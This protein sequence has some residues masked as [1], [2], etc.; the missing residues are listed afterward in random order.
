MNFLNFKATTV[1]WGKLFLKWCLKITV[2]PEVF[3]QTILKGTWNS[4]VQP[5]L[6]QLIFL[7]LPG[8]WQIYVSFHSA[9]LFTLQ[10]PDTVQEFVLLGRIIFLHVY[11]HHTSTP[12]LIWLYCIMRHIGTY[13]KWVFN[14]YNVVTGLLIVSAVHCSVSYTCAMFIQ[15]FMCQWC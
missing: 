1:F 4:S 14:P 6:P 13:L 9:S 15:I 5:L 11:G 3:L 12:I 10:R 2:N 7:L 8:L